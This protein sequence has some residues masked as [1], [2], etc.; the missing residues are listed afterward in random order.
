VIY[1]VFRRGFEK[2]PFVPSNA[3]GGADL[4]TPFGYG[5]IYADCDP[6]DSTKLMREFRR[7]LAEYAADTGVISEFVRFNPLLENH[8]L[9]RGLIDD[10]RHHNDNVVINLE[11]TL[12]EML[13]GCRQSFRAGIRQTQRRGFEMERV[14]PSEALDDFIALYREAMERRQNTGYLNFRPRFFRALFDNLGAAIEMFAVREEGRLLAAAVVLKHGATLDYFLAANKRE[15]GLA[16]I[17]HFL[18]FEIARW[19]KREGYKNFH[20]GGGAES[21]QFFKSGFSNE[22]SAYHV[23]THVFDREKYQAL[24]RAG[25]RAGR[26]PNEVPLHFFPAYRA[27]ASP[28]ADRGL[29]DALRATSCSGDD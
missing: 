27:Y 6:D 24:L 26:I 12:D 14:E 23:G 20:L 11:R 28:D 17:N 13:A 10:I 21:I 3:L 16:Y 25:Q 1:P 2:L 9:C 5:G 15:P 18:L 29:I 7:V 8:R 4:G 19:A 22:R